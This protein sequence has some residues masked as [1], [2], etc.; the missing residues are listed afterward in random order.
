MPGTEHSGQRLKLL[1]AFF[2]I[3]VIWGSTYLAI[4]YAV[5]GLPPFLMMGIRH[6]VAGGLLYGV[7]R[8]RGE[9]APPRRLWIPALIAGAVCFLGGHGLLAWAE[10]KVSSGLAALLI[11]CEPIVMVVLA[12]MM[13]QE[14]FSSRTM[15]GLVLGMAGIAVLFQTTVRQGSV[16]GA[17][18]VIVAS[19]CWSVGAIYARGV[20]TAS[21]AGLFAAMQMIMGGVLLLATG[22]VLGERINPAGVSLRCL[23][24]LVYLIVFGSLVAFSAYTWLM[25]VTTAARVTTHCYVNPVVA[26]FLGWALA[27]EAITTPMLVGTAIVVGSVI[28]V[29]T[30]QQ[31]DEKR[32]A[33]MPLE[34]VGD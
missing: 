7:L 11:A 24:A 32:P 19:V 27:G 2:A 13:G 17:I 9:A 4:R 14:K 16:M 29:T 28:L 25:R 20:K 30:K 26:V 23:S 15:F 22:S 34:V 5:D 6:V 21:S 18:A 31:G 1:A 12:R 8:F 10:I 33:E 3:Y